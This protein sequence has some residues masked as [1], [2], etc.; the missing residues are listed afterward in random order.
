MEVVPAKGRK[1]KEPKIFIEPIPPKFGTEDDIPLA[2]KRVL[3]KKDEEPKEE[4]RKQ[5]VRK[6]T[7]KVSASKPAKKRAPKETSLTPYAPSGTGRRKNKEDIDLSIVTG[8]VSIIPH[9]TC[10]ELID[11]ITKDGILKNI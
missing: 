7:I 6:V 5:P 11:E 2:F 3:R 1:R 10:A 4:A 8:N 9:K